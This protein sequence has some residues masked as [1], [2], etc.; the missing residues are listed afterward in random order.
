[1]TDDLWQAGC[2]RLA[3]ALPEQQFNTWIRPLPAAEVTSDGPDGVV[4]CLRA[5][6]R[7]KLDWIRS[8]YAS[9]IEAALAEVAREWLD[10]ATLTRR[11]ETELDGFN[12]LVGVSGVGKTKILQAL[13][14]VCRVATESDQNPGPASW[15]IGFEHDGHA[16]SWDATTAEVS[17]SATDPV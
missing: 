16:Y 11:L 10:A 7:F 5:P 14:R 1:M 8:Q 6:N 12:L 17:V 15:Q 4:V 2:E 9:R 13:R 3:A